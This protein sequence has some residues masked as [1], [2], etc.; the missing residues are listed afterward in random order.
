M[1]YEPK[2]T[3][4]YEKKSHSR[5]CGVRCDINLHAPF[6]TFKPGGIQT[7]PFPRLSVDNLGYF[8]LDLF[9]LLQRLY[10]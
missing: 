1:D 2:P 9:H 6:P 3:E 10:N 4:L 7:R 8:G 5:L